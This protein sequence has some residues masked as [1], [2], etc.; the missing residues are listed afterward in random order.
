MSPEQSRG[1]EIDSRSDI[2]SLGVVIYEML[3]KRTPFAGETP[4]DSIAAILAREPA[5]LDENTP[6]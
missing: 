2:W 5:P 1:K 4:N 6:K 3:T